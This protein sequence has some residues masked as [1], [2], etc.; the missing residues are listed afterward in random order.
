MA[1]LADW[2]CLAHGRFESFEQKCP[3]GCGQSIVSKIFINAPGIHSDRTK[4]IDKTFRNLAD[5]FGLTNMNN[6]NG[7]SAAVRP[8]PA[9]MA[10]REQLMGKL[11]DTSN[12]WGNVPSGQ[13]GVTQAIAAA[14]VSADNALQPL[15]PSLTAPK[16]LV[17]AKHD[18]E[19]K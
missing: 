16:P 12:A 15:L 11:G 10:A 9:K 7:Q 8:D 19:I 13:T 5:D 6:Q 3:H 4:N 1:V 2:E 17:V 14:R 18:A